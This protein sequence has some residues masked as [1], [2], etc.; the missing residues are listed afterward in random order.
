MKLKAVVLVSLLALVSCAS[1]PPTASFAEVKEQFVDQIAEQPDR[2]VVEIIA[3][4]RDGM[5]TVSED[6]LSKVVQVITKLNDSIE[7]LIDSSNAKVEALT[8]CTYINHKKDEIIA[9]V[10]TDAARSKLFAMG[11]QILSYVGCAAIIGAGL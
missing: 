3:D 5:C 4:C 1:A 7:S 8:H 11:K 6:T 9:L 2:V 10:K